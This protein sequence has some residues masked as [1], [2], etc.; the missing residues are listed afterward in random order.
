MLL[1]PISRS[2]LLTSVLQGLPVFYFPGTPC[3]VDEPRLH[4]LLN[5][6]R[7]EEQKEHAASTEEAPACTYKRLGVRLIV[8][9]RC[10]FGHSTQANLS[11]RQSAQATCLVISH[12]L[13][14]EEKFALL[15]MSNGVPH[16]VALLDSLACAELESQAWQGPELNASRKQLASQVSAA[17][18]VSGVGDVTFSGYNSGDLFRRIE[19]VVLAMPKPFI[20]AA[21][22]LSCHISLVVSHI[23]PSLIVNGMFSAEPS[24]FQETTSEILKT[25]QVAA[26]C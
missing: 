16:M 24:H 14:K 13:E 25:R 9:E 23:M 22:W 4:L 10:G 1:I 7:H 18:I 26:T 19:G 20:A 11:L 8:L 2:L 15:A 5:A 21:I 3:H 12:L 6:G 17:A